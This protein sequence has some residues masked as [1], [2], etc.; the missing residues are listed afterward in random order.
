MTTRLNK[1]SGKKLRTKGEK[2]REDEKYF[3]ALNVLNQAI[4]KCQ[5]ESDHTTLVDVFKDITLTWKHLFLLTKDK[6]YAALAQKSAET[7][8]SICQEFELKEKLSTS[9][10]RL[11]ETAMVIDNYKKAINY[12]KKALKVYVG[13]LSEKGDYRYHLGEVLYKNGE[14]KEGK[15]A[16]IKGLEEIRRGAHEW[17]PFYIHVWESGVHIRLAELLRNDEPREAREH[18]EKARE[19]AKADPKLVI[20]RRQVEELAKSF[21]T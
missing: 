21:K 13:K 4:V 1:L 10:F 15:K 17:D 12:Y 2:L 16:M 8:L 6:A 19:I 14:K 7:M 9:Y 11:G 3:D 20:R 5:E 18:L